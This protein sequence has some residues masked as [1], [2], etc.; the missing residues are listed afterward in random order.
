M[1]KKAKKDVDYSDKL[2]NVKMRPLVTD[3]QWRRA[4]RPFW[5]LAADVP[6]GGDTVEQVY[7]RTSIPAFHKLDVYARTVAGAVGMRA[8]IIA[9]DSAG[10]EPAA[11]AVIP[12]EAEEAKGAQPGDGRSPLLYL[13][14]G[15]TW[16][17]ATAQHYDRSEGDQ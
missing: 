6:A 13:T 2:V 1:G 16:N 9:G 14:W 15:R 17:A 3:D 8:G 4:G 12:W 10:L 11:A 7:Y 5:L